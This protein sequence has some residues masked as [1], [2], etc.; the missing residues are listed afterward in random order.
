[1]S[2]AFMFI[3]LIFARTTE[4]RLA[5]FFAVFL[6]SKITPHEKSFLKAGCT[7]MAITLSYRMESTNLRIRRD[8]LA[9]RWAIG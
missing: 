3:L 6:E 1:M 8:G 7:R 5:H 2:I 4:T 9:G